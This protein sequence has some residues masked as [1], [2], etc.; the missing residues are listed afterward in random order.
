MNI[1]ADYQALGIQLGI[2]YDTIKEIQLK[3]CDS[4]MCYR[5]MLA[6]WY[7]YTVDGNRAALLLEA[8]RSR[9]IDNRRL[10]NDLEINWRAANYC[11]FCFNPASSLSPCALHCVYV[12]IVAHH[13][14]LYT[15]HI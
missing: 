4:R 6:E 9:A 1:A 8:I 11:E 3:L 12:Y 2:P 7:G 15:P 14:I 10:A 5:D 13:M